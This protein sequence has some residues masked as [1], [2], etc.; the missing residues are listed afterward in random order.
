MLSVTLLLLCWVS[1]GQMSFCWLSR[2]HLEKVQHLRFS[3][4]WEIAVRSDHSINKYLLLT[5]AKRSV[6]QDS[7]IAY[8]YAN[9]FKMFFS[10]KGAFSRPIWLRFFQCVLLYFV[11]SLS[12]K[13]HQ[14][15]TFH[16]SAFTNAMAGLKTIKLTLKLDVSMS[17]NHNL[18]IN[19]WSSGLHYKIS[20]CCN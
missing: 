7:K 17:L 10:V 2:C 18:N 8:F 12:L 20:Y 16:S 11:S 15:L 9:I 6:N 14:T 4:R 5:I 3:K 19:L 13:T 1:L